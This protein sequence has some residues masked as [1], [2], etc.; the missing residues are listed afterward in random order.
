MHDLQRVDIRS[1]VAHDPRTVPG[2]VRVLNSGWLVQIIIHFRKRP[3]TPS[4]LYTFLQL[5]EKTLQNLKTL[6]S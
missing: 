2:R 1:R 3:A 6:G 5:M 4:K